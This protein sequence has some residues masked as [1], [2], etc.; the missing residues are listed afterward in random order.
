MNAGHGIKTRL[1]AG[2]GLAAQIRW[3]NPCPAPGPG[4]VPRMGR[5][6]GEQG[7]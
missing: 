6:V 5:R 1:Q 4:S 7:R 3:R 2:N